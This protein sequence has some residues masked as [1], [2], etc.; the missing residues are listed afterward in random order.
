MA[1]PSYVGPAGDN[2][3]HWDFGAGPE[4]VPH[5]V[6]PPPSLGVGGLDAPQLPGFGPPPSASPFGGGFLA[7]AAQSAPAP[8]APGDLRPLPSPEAPERAQEQLSGGRE[9]Q[10]FALPRRTGDPGVDDYLFSLSRA[11]EAQSDADQRRAIGRQEAVGEFER[12]MKQSE[13]IRAEANKRYEAELGQVRQD[14]EAVR[15]AKIDPD[16]GVFSGPGNEWRMILGGIGI[17]LSGL[18]TGGRGP[19]P[20]MQIIDNAISR[21]VDSQKANLANKRAALGDRMNLLEA[22]RRRWNDDITADNLTAAQMYDAALKKVEAEAQGIE[23]PIAKL[24]Y[25]EIAQNLVERRDER[26]EAVRA[27]REQLAQ[28]WAGLNIQQQELADRRAERE[29]VRQAKT[30][31]AS[32]KGMDRAVVGVSD[33]KDPQKVVIAVTEKDGQE[34]NAMVGASQ[35]MVNGF[36][37]LNEIYSRA[38]WDSAKLGGEAAKEA[39]TILEDLKLTYATAKGQGAVSEGDAARYDKIFGDDPTG[40]YDLRGKWQAM[41]GRLVSRVNANIRARTINGR[42]LG[43]SWKPDEMRPKGAREGD[44]IGTRQPSGRQGPRGLPALAPAP[45]PSLLRGDLGDLTPSREGWEFYK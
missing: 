19:N 24:K 29:A 16:G 6:L 4:L 20:A 21:A 36:R 43:V 41:E 2:W 17:G 38:G 34:L 33:F 39:Q 28:G 9:Q 35:D 5:A 25:Q 37:R 22:N 15:S 40:I 42:E 23:S 3:S 32:A 31:A 11:G 10:A 12:R 30:D 1:G 26:Q 27:R 8:P 18:A 7:S 45:S 13:A 44:T 14:M